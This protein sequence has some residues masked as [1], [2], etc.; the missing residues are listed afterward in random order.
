MQTTLF[1]LYWHVSRPD[2]SSALYHHLAPDRSLVDELM[3][4]AGRRRDVRT[5][6]D[7]YDA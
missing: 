7:E 3:A 1:M 2:G 6:G 4:D 5:S